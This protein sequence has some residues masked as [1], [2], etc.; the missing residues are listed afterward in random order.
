M[1]H[2]S[3]ETAIRTGLE[4]VDDVEARFVRLPP[5]GRAALLLSNNLPLLSSFDLDAQ[6]IRWH[7]TQAVRARRA[8]MPELGTFR[9]DV[10]HVNSH[11][12]AFGLAGVMRRIP[13]FLSLDAT[14]EDWHRLGAWRKAR[15]QSR[16]M[17][18]P[19]LRRER[20]ALA[21]AAAVLAWTDWARD[22]A[23]RACP[24][25]RVRTL[26]PGVD[27][28]TFRPAPHRSRE[29]PTVLFV[30][31]RFGQ[32]GGFDLIDALAPH[33]GRTV[34]LD[35]VTPSDVAPRDGL[36]VHRLRRDDPAL[37][38]LYQ[39]ADVFCLPTHADS[40]G[41]VILEAM[42]CGTPV[43]ASAVGGIP[44]V[45][46]HGRTGVLVAPQDVTGLRA[47]IEQLLADKERRAELGRRSRTVCQERYDARRQTA[48]LVR[49]T[50]LAVEQRA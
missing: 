39:Q 32:K 19:S 49:L 33:L 36:R 16:L 47:A 9:P 45:L 6:T 23:E 4:G 46:D 41:W 17:L 27:L 20:R 25:A 13:T 26:N 2:V 40:M 50:R 1:G 10:L 37:V 14:V 22:A 38:E 24:Q 12:I 43:I 30:G 34:E 7:A 48:E 31:G 3:L 15:R 8:L 5:M 28:E 18:E 11:T 35:V 21:E 44:E 29:R 42:A